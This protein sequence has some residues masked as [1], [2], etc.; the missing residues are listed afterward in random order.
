MQ[1]SVRTIAITGATAFVG[2]RVV[3]RLLEEPELALRKRS[4]R[5]APSQR[6]LKKDRTVGGCIRATGIPA[7]TEEGHPV[8]TRRYVLLVGS[9]MPGHEMLCERSVPSTFDLVSAPLSWSD[10]HSTPLKGHWGAWESF[11]SPS[12][13]SQTPNCAVLNAMRAWRTTVE[14]RWWRLPAAPRSAGE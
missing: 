12:G 4:T 8:L 5:F 1:S 11:L 2:R 7:R 10:S 9:F 14:G 6:R 13:S 3:K